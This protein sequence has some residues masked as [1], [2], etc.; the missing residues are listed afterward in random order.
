MFQN[1]FQ[2]SRE[3]KLPPKSEFLLPWSILAYSNSI[4]SARRMKQ[5]GI[6]ENVLKFIPREQGGKY[7][8]QT[9]QIHSLD[10]DFSM[11]LLDRF[12]LTTWAIRWIQKFSAVY[13][14]EKRWETAPPPERVPNTAFSFLWW[15]STCSSSINSSQQLIET[16]WYTLSVSEP[17]LW[18][19]CITDGSLNYISTVYLKSNLNSLERFSSAQKLIPSNPKSISLIYWLIFRQLCLGRFSSP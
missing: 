14:T 3:E 11:Q 6:L 7:C 17:F 13:W 19:S 16:I 4:K 12:S 8:P 10:C 1:S 9:I 2:G 5:L 18:G 15:I